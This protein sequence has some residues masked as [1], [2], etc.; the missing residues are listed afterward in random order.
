MSRPV[1]SRAPARTA[2]V[3]TLV[4]VTSRTSAWDFMAPRLEEAAV[5]GNR[6]VGAVKVAAGT[7]VPA[8]LEGCQLV[9][10][11]G[12]SPRAIPPEH[13]KKDI[14]SWRDARM[15]PMFHGKRFAPI[16]LAHPPGCPPLLPLSGG[17]SLLPPG[18]THR[19]AG[20]PPASTNCRLRRCG[21]ADGGSDPRSKVRTVWRIRFA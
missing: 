13:G 16:F 4:T 10:G 19:P 6:D 8:N 5:L 9:Y 1:R 7:S 21:G 11:G 12:A 18:T 2:S 17:R 3:S 15:R 14:P 20:K